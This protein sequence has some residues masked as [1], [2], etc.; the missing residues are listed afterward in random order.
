MKLR[1]PEVVQKLLLLKADVDRADKYGRTPLI[2]SIMKGDEHIVEML[3]LAGADVEVSDA[4]F[5][6]P[7][8]KA[9]ELNRRGIVEK[10][11]A[12]GAVTHKR[13]K[14]RTVK[15]VFL[16]ILFDGGCVGLEIKIRYLIVFQFI[17]FGKDAKEVTR[18]ELI[19]Q[20]LHRYAGNISFCGSVR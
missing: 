11:L 5:K 15:Y 10:L 8:I 2:T 3:L 4:D 20:V 17:Q 19:K 6:T 12:H 16:R 18:N 1:L 13:D 7:L 9:S 14:V